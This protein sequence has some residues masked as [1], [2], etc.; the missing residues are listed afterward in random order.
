LLDCETEVGAC[1]GALEDEYDLV[2]REPTLSGGVEGM[3]YGILYGTEE[4]E[5]EE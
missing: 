1:T 2:Y 5:A 3:D 4:V